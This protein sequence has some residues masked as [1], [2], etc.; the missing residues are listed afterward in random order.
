MK[1]DSA[2]HCTSKNQTHPT[3]KYGTCVFCIDFMCIGM[4]L[5][6]VN[7]LKPQTCS[8]LSFGC[9]CIQSIRHALTQA[10]RYVYVGIIDIIP[11]IDCSHQIKP[12]AIRKSF[13]A[14]GHFDDNNIF[15]AYFFWDRRR[16]YSTMCLTIDIFLHLDHLRKMLDQRLGK[17]KKQSSKHLYSD[18][19]HTKVQKKRILFR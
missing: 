7:L 3:I 13:S 4:L 6:K 1:S 18:Q 9:T 19:P 10:L 11:P 5:A 16:S 15:T 14:A 12:H 8:L 2:L 17:A